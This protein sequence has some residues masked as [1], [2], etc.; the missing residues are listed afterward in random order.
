MSYPSRAPAAAVDES[1]KETFVVSSYEISVQTLAGNSVCL[2]ALQP[3]DTIRDLALSIRSNHAIP[4]SVQHL[5]WGSTVLNEPAEQ[6]RST[7]GDAHCPELTLL[8]RP[9]TPAERAE[10]HRR[11]VR[12]TAAGEVKQVRELLREGAQVNFCPELPGDD[13]SL[14]LNHWEEESLSAHPDPTGIAPT[15]CAAAT[16]DSIAQSAPASSAPDTL[17]VWGDPPDVDSEDA[18]DEE[19]GET[20][21]DSRD[22][23]KAPGHPCGGLT[24]LLVA[25]LAGHEELTRDFI[26]LGA[27][28]V[29]LQPCKT[30]DMKEAFACRDFVEIMGH[31]AKGA[32][33]NVRMARGRGVPGALDVWSIWPGSDATFG[34]PLH[35]LAAMHALPGAYETAQLLIKLR[36]D[37]NAADTEGDTPLAHARYFRAQALHELYSGKGAKLSGPYYRRFQAAQDG[38]RLLQLA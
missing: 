38:W 34:T 24:P 16:A 10:L 15:V 9:F 17:D 37:L 7:F 36:A 11:L 22:G 2:P 30:S 1:N 29:N 13:A 6:L 32:D 8:R 35:A 5:V 19:F 25:R 28:D 26:Q 18:E 14:A 23:I 3:T 12:A 33:L 21:D 31:A 27:H 20:P 4:I